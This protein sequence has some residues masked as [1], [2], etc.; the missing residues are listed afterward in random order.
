[1]KPPFCSLAVAARRGSPS[2][3]VALDPKFA[4][5]YNGR[6]NAYYGKGDLDH[7]I[8][9]YNQAI[10]LDPKFALAYNDRSNA[11]MARS[12]WTGPN[13]WARSHRPTP[14]SDAPSVPRAGW[15]AI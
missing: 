10:T 7:A 9:D 5:A 8:A 1:M 3:A 13:W 14:S 4:L 6:G 15:V 2:A 11:Y 12:T